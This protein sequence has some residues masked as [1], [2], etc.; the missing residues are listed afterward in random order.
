M[1]ELFLKIYYQKLDEPI[2]VNTESDVSKS[3]IVNKT[4][5]KTQKKEDTKNTTTKELMEVEVCE[6][7]IVDLG[8]AGVRKEKVCKIKKSEG[9]ET[10]VNSKNNTNK[11]NQKAKI[12]LLNV[13]NLGT[14]QQKIDFLKTCKK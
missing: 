3:E 14:P 11:E 1:M 13:K 6:E 7:V 5:S 8:I 12:Q 9:V 10:K 2:E 4:S